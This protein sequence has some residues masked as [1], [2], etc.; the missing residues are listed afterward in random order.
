MARPSSRSRR[1]T[2]LATL[3][4]ALLAVAPLALAS[5]GTLSES[6]AKKKGNKAA[7]SA[8]ASASAAPTEEPTPPP[9]ATVEPEP[10]PSATETK[11]PPEAGTVSVA[12]DNPEDD[13]TDVYEDPS[14]T[15]YFI[16][17]R[18]RGTIVPSFIEHLFVDDGRTFYSNTIGAEVDIRKGGNSIILSLGY[19]EYGFDDTLFKQKN[20]PDTANNYTIVN[21]GLKGVYVGLDDLWSTPLV[22]HLDLEY[23][24]NVGLGAIF[25]DLVNNWAWSPSQS[26]PPVEPGSRNYPNNVIHGADGNTY[27]KCFSQTDGVG[28][29]TSDHQNATTAKVGNYVEKNW[30]NGGVVPV[31][32]P[33]IGGQIGLRYKPIKQVETRLSIGISLLEGFFFNLSADYGLPVDEGHHRSPAATPPAKEPSPDSA[34]SDKN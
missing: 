3:A 2:F 14:K 21:S 13:I 26:N 11:T 31:I 24:F 16:G 15:H 23:G 34:T 10:A 32:F 28:C 22:N 17:A 8:S 25:G 20:V 9:A 7:P 6:K 29:S 12:A 30:F 1:H 5:Q 33:R 27:A 19:T 18:Y 4:L